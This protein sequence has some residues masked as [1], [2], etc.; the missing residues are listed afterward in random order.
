MSI[1][2]RS[3]R[4]ALALL[5][6]E[7]VKDAKELS[8]LERRHIF[9]TA[10]VI[11]LTAKIPTKN[12]KVIEIEGRIVRNE[13]LLKKLEGEQAQESDMEEMEVE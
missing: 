13:A 2:I 10:L 8:R 6:K 5:R 3:K 1:E 12:A 9:L 7:Q 4:K 11:T